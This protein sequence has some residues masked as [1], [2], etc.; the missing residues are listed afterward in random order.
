MYFD[1]TNGIEGFQ[2][3]ADDQPFYINEAGNPV[4]VFAK[5][6]IAPGSMGQQE[7]EIPVPQE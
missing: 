4:V 7:F 1:G 2:S 6:E 5:Y 3:I